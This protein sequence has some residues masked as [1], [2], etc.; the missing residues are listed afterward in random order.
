[1]TIITVSEGDKSMEPAV[2]VDLELL[3]KIDAVEM[4]EQRRAWK[5]AVMA[6]PYKIH[7]DRQYYATESWRQTEGE[8]LEIR[9]AKL[10]K[11][12]VENI[13]LSILPYDYIVGRMGPTV[14]GAYTGIDSCG[15]YL[16]GIWSDEGKVQFSLNSQSQ[17]SPEDLEILR[18]AARE[19][20][21]K[22]VAD[23]GNLL[24]K[25]LL[26]T[27]PQDV[28]E[29]RLKD[30]PLNTGNWANST[31]TIDFNKII[32][33]GLRYF[34]DEAQ[35]HINDFVENQGQN[36]N[37]FWFWKA[38]IIVCEAIITL[39]HRYAA[40]AR[41]M[42]KT[43]E[44]PARKKQ[45]IEIAEACEHVPEFPARSFHEA[46]QSM[47]ITG[48]SKGIEHP[49]HNHPQWGRGDQYLYPFFIRDIQTGTISVDKAVNMLAEL[50]G[51]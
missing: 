38:A 20:G 13:K 11:H 35:G 40:L 14:V 31:N 4:D 48:I 10:F 42:E 6:A 46:L 29:A 43:E 49:M 51:R 50:T 23:A 32:T 41:E 47:A 22:S 12:V 9:R 26:G 44:D 24:W 3:K 1:M 28:L 34:I 45:L 21:G 25:E 39:S 15:D 17:L 8:D 18:D 37:K 7:T 27:W 2:K 19:F 33:K 36:A 16:D 30:P 5:K